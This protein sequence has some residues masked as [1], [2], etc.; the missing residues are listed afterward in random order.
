MASLALMVSLILFCVIFSG[1]IV[2]LLSKCSFI[3]NYIVYVLSIITIF[4]GVWFFLLPIAGIRYFGVISSLLAWFAIQ[5][6]RSET[7]KG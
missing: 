2:L 6:R 3:P 1:P 5:N 7:I 4:F